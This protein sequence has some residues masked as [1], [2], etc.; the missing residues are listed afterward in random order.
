MIGINAFF[1]DKLSKTMHFIFGEQ[2]AKGF[3]ELLYWR[4]AKLKDNKLSNHHYEYFYTTHFGLNKSFYTYKKILDVGCGPRGSLEWVD[5][6][7]ERI[8]L[9]PLADSYAKLRKTNHRMKYVNS[10]SE[11]IPFEDGYFD[12]VTTFNSLDHV[13][14]LD[15]TI[16]EIKRV[17]KTNG[18]LLLITDIHDN[19]TVCE[20]N[21]FGWDIL[22][23]FKDTFEI[24]KE[25]HFERKQIYQSLRERI[26]FNHNN[27]K[28]R[29][30]LLSAILRKK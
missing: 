25:E 29:Y 10:G 15:S 13:D 5:N 3:F 22:E 27:S 20:P 24:E 17:L 1:Y 9:D 8:G 14:N 6:A 16:A 23:K 19:P 18:T 28:E 11:N 2:G 4:I 12:I 7:K 21:A 30:G 26:P